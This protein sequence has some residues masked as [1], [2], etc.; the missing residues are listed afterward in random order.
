M[1]SAAAPTELEEFVEAPVAF[2]PAEPGA[3]LVSTPR[4][5]LRANV[6]GWRTSVQRIRLGPD[7]IDD[8]LE[9]VRS[10]MRVTGTPVGSWWISEHSTPTGLEASLLTRGLSIVEDDY[11]IDGL[12]LTRPPAAAPAGVVARAVESAEEYALAVQAQDDAF[13]TPPARRVSPDAL[14]EE[15][16][17]TYDP[18][19]SRLYA[20]WVDGRIAGGGRASFSTRGVH[21][22]GGSTAPWA[23]GCGAYRALVRARWD[24]AVERGTPALAVSAGAMSAPILHRLGFEKVCQFRRLQDVLDAA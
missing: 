15:Y 24:A 20:V 8:A 16:R 11:L 7:E 14:V 4:Y 12:L 17:A 2:T 1:S 23:R 21:M 18:D 6:G 19:V 9:A 10:F 3:V 5:V 22:T 13:E